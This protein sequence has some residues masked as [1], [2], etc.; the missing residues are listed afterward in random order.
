MSMAIIRVLLYL[1]LNGFD[2]KNTNSFLAMEMQAI[3][4]ALSVAIRAI[5]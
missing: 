2:W 3:T 5:V 4:S 1:S